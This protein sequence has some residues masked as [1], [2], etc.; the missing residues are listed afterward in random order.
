M[1]ETALTAEQRLRAAVAHYCNE[2]PQEVIAELFGVN[3]GRINEA[4]R[5]IWCVAENPKRAREVLE[6]AGMIA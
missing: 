1:R 2:V 5:V 4:C 3:G 6:A